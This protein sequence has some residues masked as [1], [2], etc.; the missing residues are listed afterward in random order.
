MILKKNDTGMCVSI[1]ITRSS[2]RPPYM[3]SMIILHMCLIALSQFALSQFS[4]ASE[5]KSMM[6]ARNGEGK[7]G[8]RH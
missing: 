6:D 1:F 8:C 7:V 2:K 4:I 3:S 5:M